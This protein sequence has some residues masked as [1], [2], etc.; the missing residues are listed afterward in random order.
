M[1]RKPQIVVVTPALADANNGNWR[2]ARR[3]ARMLGSAY[4]VRLTK[5]WSPLDSLAAG[6]ELMIALHARRSAASVAA[7][8][9]AR[10]SAPL[11]LALTGTDLYR[12]IDDDTDAQRSLAWADGLVVLNELGPARLPE[13]YRRR[14]EVVLQSCTARRPVA[15]KPQ[16]LARA[17][18]VGHLRAEKDPGTWFRA[19]RRLALRADLRF[20][21]IG[22]ALE[23]R[24]ADEARALMQQVPAYRWLG[25]R[26]HA[27]TRR[28]IQSAHVLV[29]PS[30]MEGGAQ[31]VIEAIRSGTPVLAS[32][33][34]GNVGLLGADY[35][36]YFD[37]GDDRGL[38]ALL[39]RTRDDPAMLPTLAR[40]IERRAPLFAPEAESAALHRVV[41]RL[42]ADRP[43]LPSVH[44]AAHPIPTPAG[45]TR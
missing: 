15:A 43:P 8:H 14:C 35:G 33:M 30:V 13:A 12:D 28:R 9:S 31:V 24:L 16:R 45:D 11:L 41:R 34:D 1:H 42:L 32:R 18:M 21:H 6:D 40:Q 19:V 38:A 29:H 23:P 2:T 10:G 26:L 7:W 27:E 3:W 22:E 17:L 39:E 44:A 36:G 25:A 37:V 5:S 4:R 20:D